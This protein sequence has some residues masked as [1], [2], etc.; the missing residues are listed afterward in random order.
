[1]TEEIDDS[2]ARPLCGQPGARGLRSFL[3]KEPAIVDT[4]LGSDH[5]AIREL[6]EDVVVYF[7]N[8]RMLWQLR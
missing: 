4:V 6:P 5:S 3:V 2:A 7:K 1:M 8:I